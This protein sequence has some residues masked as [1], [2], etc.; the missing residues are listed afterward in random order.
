MPEVA[1]LRRRSCTIIVDR[2]AG[3]EAIRGTYLYILPIALRSAVV[4]H[5]KQGPTIE[6][7]ITYGSHAIWNG[8]RGERGATI[9]RIIPNAR[10]ATPNGDR[11]KR[12]AIL[13]RIIL[14]AR[15][16]VYGNRL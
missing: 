2:R 8:N 3:E 6:R 10:N 12:G 1:L 13:K 9:E 16:S 15:A 11:G 14:N 5:F 7:T 4:Y